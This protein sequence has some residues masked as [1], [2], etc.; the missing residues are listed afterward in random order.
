MRYIYLCDCGK[1]LEYELSE[2]NAVRDFI[3]I[4]DL[5]NGSDQVHLAWEH[6]AQK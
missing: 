2:R 5:H 3:Y 4:I 6:K 1:Y